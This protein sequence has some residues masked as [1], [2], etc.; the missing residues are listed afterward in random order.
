MK[1]NKFTKAIIVAVS[2]LLLAGVVFGISAL[3]ESSDGITSVEI[4][5]KNVSYAG[6]P[7]LVYYVGTDA[8]LAENQK[9]KMFFWD[10]KNTTGL[11][12][13][14]T[15]EYSKYP[16]SEAEI[17][18]ETY[19]TVLGKG[20]A[21]SEVRLSVYARPAVVEVA[22]DGSETVVLYGDLLEYSIFDYALEMF[23]AKVNG[24]RGNA[25][26][27]QVEIYKAF[28]D[29][30]AA[31]QEKLFTNSYNGVLNEKKLEAVGG[32]ADAYYVIQI[33][34]YLYNSSTNEYV[35][36]GESTR[37]S[38]RRANEDIVISSDMYYTKSGTRYAFKSY[39][40][41]DGKPL[42]LLSSYGNEYITSRSV[43]STVYETVSQTEGVVEYN[44]YYGVETGHYITFD[45]GEPISSL[46]SKNFWAQYDATTSYCKSTL[47]QANVT[48]Y[49]YQH[50]EN[51]EPVEITDFYTS[52][53]VTKGSTFNDYHYAAIKTSNNTP[54]TGKISTSSNYEFIDI[55]GTDSR[56]IKKIVPMNASAY[57]E[58]VSAPGNDPSNDRGNVVSFVKH[59]YQ[60]NAETGEKETHLTGPVYSNY[61]K[62]GYQSQGYVRALGSLKISSSGT[63]ASLLT[64]NGSISFNNTSPAVVAD[65]DC[66]TVHIVDFDFYLSSDQYGKT[67]VQILTDN[68]L[69][70]FNLG[71]NETTGVYLYDEKSPAYQSGGARYDAEGN[72]I[73]SGKDGTLLAGANGGDT[74]GKQMQPDSWY[75][76]RIEYIDREDDQ[77][78][79]LIYIDGELVSYIRGGKNATDDSKMAS[80]QLNFA[81][82]TR[83][84]YFYMDDLYISSEG[85]YKK[86]ASDTPSTDVTY[87]DDVYTHGSGDYHGQGEYAELAATVESGYKPANGLK[88][89]VTVTEEK[90]SDKTKNTALHMLKTNGTGMSASVAADVLGGNLYVFETDIKVVGG[91]TTGTW[92]LKLALVNSAITAPTDANTMASVCIDYMGDYWTLSNY[93]SAYNS[94]LKFKLNEWHNLRF[95]FNPAN[96]ELTVWIN[97]VLVYNKVPYN[98]GDGKNDSAFAGVSMSM[99]GSKGGTYS[100]ILFDNMYATTLYRDYHG[101]GENYKDSD[102]YDNYTSGT[103]VTVETENGDTYINNTENTI[104]GS[105]AHNR[106]DEY[107]F[108]TD[109]RWNGATGF[110]NVDSTTAKVL[111]FAMKSGTNNIFSLSGVTTSNSASNLMLKV[112]TVTV[113]TLARD[114]WMNLRIVYTPHEAEVVD[115]ETVYRATYTIYINGNSAYESTIECDHYDTFDSASLVIKSEFA[116]VVPSIDLDNTYTAACYIDD[117]GAGEHYSDANHYGES[118]LTI[119]SSQTFES[120]ISIGSHYLFEADIKWVSGNATIA[121]TSLSGNDLV[122]YIVPDTSNAGY[123][124]LSLNSDGSDAFFTIYMGVWYNLQLEAEDGVYAVNISGIQR[125]Y[126]ERELAETCNGAKIEVTSGSSLVVDNTYM[127]VENNNYSGRGENKDNAI[128]NYTQAVDNTIIFDPELAETDVNNKYTDAYVTV[129]KSQIVLG[130]NTAMSEN[131]VSFIGGKNADLHIFES[132]ITWGGTTLGIETPIT[133]TSNAAFFTVTLKDSDGNAVL[134]VYAVG[135][136][137]KDSVADSINFLGLYTSLDDVASGNAFAYICDG[138]TFNLRVEYKAT[139]AYEIFVNNKSVNTGSG[140]A[141]AAMGG[142]DVALGNSVYD[143]K[144]T[145]KYTAIL[146]K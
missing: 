12:N 105:P 127:L 95:E 141:C 111:E 27:D 53:G 116:E 124:K 103:G 110:E 139:G 20:T 73:G 101:L 44:A 146:S 74:I 51:S 52:D 33:N 11:Y 9:I 140:N 47:A 62:S 78:T 41:A 26:E 106:G 126:V 81:T 21:P 50:D 54:A 99:R 94:S 113:A 132:D 60:V 46:S 80:F 48:L 13:E 122:V 68:T 98:L 37:Y 45:D 63:S 115:G 121:L 123:A 92:M 70:K 87:Y 32:W 22:E 93:G 57:A 120:A 36:E 88:S 145:L 67:L 25:A 35:A 5:Y 16:T 6:S 72:K 76:L 18:G 40:D 96:D 137:N 134:T 83:C 131:L 69:F 143:T 114:Y 125:A 31:V 42:H 117:L 34:R 43:F 14:H 129:T 24:Q 100:E 66:Y 144:L 108:E 3:A 89:G 133:N 17:D 135:I 107:I 84:S 56:I 85:N 58:V 91:D 71:L 119:T 49:Y 136:Y 109:I 30:A 138:V 77:A 1:N 65:P 39:R 112:G 28:L 104:T 29:Y 7:S 130:K 38:A 82:D 8:P 4:A 86:A 128:N 75:N 90:L 79:V 23:N 59:L 61:N 55:N 64:N 102:K 97:N 142:V 15:A 19:H 118:D 2:C 10:S